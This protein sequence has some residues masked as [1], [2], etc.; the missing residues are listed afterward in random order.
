MIKVYGRPECSFCDRAKA[1]L[2]SKDVAYEYIDVTQDTDA[3]QLLVDA[4]F[5]SVP[6]IY[7]DTQHI[8]GGFQ[9]LAGMT[10]EDFNTKVRN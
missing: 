2:E 1:L 3:R 4:G 10:E 7:N 9:G 5:R 8:P 6:Q